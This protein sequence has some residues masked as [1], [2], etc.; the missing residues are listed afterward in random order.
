MTKSWLSSRPQGQR[1]WEWQQR[2]LQLAN[3]HQ[4]S[5]HSKSSHYKNNHESYMGWIHSLFTWTSL[6][7]KP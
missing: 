5:L 1:Q 4:V 7:R 6:S 3:R 2:V